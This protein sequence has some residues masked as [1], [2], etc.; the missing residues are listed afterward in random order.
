MKCFSPSGDFFTP[1]GA[2]GYPAERDRPSGPFAY[3]YVQQRAT[4]QEKSPDLHFY[5]AHSLCRFELDT[6]EYNCRRRTNRDGVMT[7]PQKKLDK[8]CLI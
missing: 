2:L 8:V 7:L 1:S 4:N 6:D 3:Q 5:V